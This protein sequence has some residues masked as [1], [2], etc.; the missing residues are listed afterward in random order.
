MLGT[1]LNVTKLHWG[2]TG[3]DRRPSGSR[4]AAGF[5]V[6]GRRCFQLADAPKLVRSATTLA[7]MNSRTR[8]LTTSR[9][10]TEVSLLPLRTGGYWEDEG[11]EWFAV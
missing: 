11:Y 3:G 6:R 9:A 4:A 5:G 1:R 2:V 8:R 10:L 7:S